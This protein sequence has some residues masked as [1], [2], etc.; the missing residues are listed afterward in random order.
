MKKNSL[1]AAGWALLLA[2]V[3]VIG[4]AQQWFPE[5]NDPKPG[6]DMP[7]GLQKLNYTL[8]AAA[9]VSLDFLPEGTEPAPG[10]T[11]AR[12]LQKINQL[13]KYGAISGGGSVSD[14]A[15]NATTW[16]GD[17]N[18]PSKNAVRDKIEALA[19]SIPAAGNLAPAFTALTDGATVTL[20]CD[21]TKVSQNAT[22]TLGGNRTLAISGAA[23][24]MTGILKVVQDGTGSRTLTLPAGSKVFSGGSGA[25]TLTTTASAI[26]I[27]TWIYDGTNYFWN[28]GLNYN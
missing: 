16:N 1:S 15:Y 7:R 11:P 20:T 21:A 28:K 8:Y 22:V 25:V 6:D 2:A 24:G 14:V 17:T 19:A 18:A 5:G 13:V 27:L 3:S 12:S 4:L 23:A 10:D 9:P 26:D